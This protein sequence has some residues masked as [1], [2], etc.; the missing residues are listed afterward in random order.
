MSSSEFLL[1]DFVFLKYVIPATIMTKA[2]TPEIDP[3]IMDT[4]D[5]ATFGSTTISEYIS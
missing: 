5:S 3:A 2:M 4:F 1:T